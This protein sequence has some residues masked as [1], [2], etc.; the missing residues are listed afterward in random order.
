MVLL[1]KFDDIFRLKHH[2][3]I[4]CD[5]KNRYTGATS[6]HSASAACPGV[7]RIVMAY[8]RLSP[9]VFSGRQGAGALRHAVSL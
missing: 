2:S 8:S 9:S 1:D 4:N 3:V 5:D 6:A 7:T